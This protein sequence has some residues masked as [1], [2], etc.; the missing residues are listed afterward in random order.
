MTLTHIRLSVHVCCVQVWIS[1]AQFEL[2]IEG[3]ERLHWCRQVY[4]E[5]NRSLRTCEEK[6]ERLMLLEAWKDFEQEFG[7]LANKDR[8]RKLMPEKVKKRRKL[9]AEDGVSQRK[10]AATQTV[11]SQHMQC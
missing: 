7:T 4:E 3:A 10:Q 2:S 1:Y 9:T 11:S 6:E 8:V 5:A